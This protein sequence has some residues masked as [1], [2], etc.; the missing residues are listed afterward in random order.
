MKNNILSGKFA[1]DSSDNPSGLYK[2]SGCVFN[3]GFDPV[4]NQVVF[5]ANIENRVIT[6]FQKMTTISELK[7]F[8]GFDVIGRAITNPNGYYEIMF[9]IRAF[10]Q[11]ENNSLSVVA[12]ATNNVQIIGW[13]QIAAIKDFIKNSEV[14]NMNIHLSNSNKNILYGNIKSI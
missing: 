1:G 7:A 12:F 14:Q 13:S 3:A 5:A 2:L 8:A 4:D 6:I 11:N 10:Q 9:R